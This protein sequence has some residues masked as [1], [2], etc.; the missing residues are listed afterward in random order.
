MAYGLLLNNENT[1]TFVEG[2]RIAFYSTQRSGIS[3]SD[4]FHFSLVNF[5]C[6]EMSVFFGQYGSILSANITSPFNNINFDLNRFDFSGNVMNLSRPNIILLCD[7]KSY[8]SGIGKTVMAGD[9]PLY[10]KYI[11]NYTDPNNVYIKTEDYPFG[12]STSYFNQ[13]FTKLN[14]AATV[15]NFVYVKYSDTN[16]ERIFLATPNG[17]NIH[18]SELPTDKF[19]NEVD[20]YIENVA[21]A[22]NGG[23]LP[24]SYFKDIMP[25]VGS[26]LLL[27]NAKFDDVLSGLYM[28]AG[29]EAEVQLNRANLQWNHPG[30]TFNARIDISYSTKTNFNPGCYFVPFEYGETS[31][32]FSKNLLLRRF[33]SQGVGSTSLY[34]PLYRDDYDQSSLILN[35]S[36]QGLHTKQSDSFVLGLGVSNWFPDAKLFGVTL[37]YEIKEGY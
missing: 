23:T 12:L 27:N 24:L 18:W 28:V 20:Y 21:S 30:Q 16:I 33:V 22:F 31:E 4:T 26:T 11:R 34:F 15:Q 7:I 29:I 1:G 10:S 14:P 3:T 32:A 9:F 13:A 19:Y 6:S 8:E 25:E 5:T 36:S 17:S 2:N 37:N 35:L